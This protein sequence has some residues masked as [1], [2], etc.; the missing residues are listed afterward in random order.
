[1]GVLAVAWAGRA[2]EISQSFQLTVTINPE[3][4]VSLSAPSVQIS[5]AG[6]GQQ[7]GLT[8]LLKA[9]AP[10]SLTLTPDASAVASLPAGS[11]DWRLDQGAWQGLSSGLSTSGGDPTGDSGRQFSVEFV[12]RPSFGH[13]AGTYSVPFAVTASATL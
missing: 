5:N 3:V 4:Q 8:V 13:R 10:W 12:Y 6:S 7:A 11:V 9:N 2:A 1:M